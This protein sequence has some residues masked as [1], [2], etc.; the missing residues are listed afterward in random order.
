ARGVSRPQAAV[1]IAVDQLLLLLYGRRSHPGNAQAL[2]GKPEGQV[3][4]SLTSEQTVQ[5][6]RK[7][8]KYTL[9]PT[10]EQA[11]ALE[12]VLWRWWTLCNCALE[13]RKTWWERGQ[14]KGATYNQQ[15]AELPDLKTACPQC[16]DVPAQVLQDVLLRLDHTFQAFFRRVAA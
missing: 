6:L 12:E 2:R 10:P 8:F 1:A 11:Q 14:G 13:Q 3:E 15:Q 5:T 9:M 16:A 4:V 7:T